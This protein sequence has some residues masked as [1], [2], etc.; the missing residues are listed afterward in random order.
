MTD[1]AASK[2][3]VWPRAEKSVFTH[4]RGSAAKAELRVCPTQDHAF[5]TQ[6]EGGNSK[7]LL[8]NSL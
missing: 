1:S 5:I 8:T 2:G 4:E 3:Q 6:T 7:V